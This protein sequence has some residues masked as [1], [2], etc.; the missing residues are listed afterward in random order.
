M[1]HPFL[2][3]E[4]AEDAQEACTRIDLWRLRK[5]EELARFDPS[6]PYALSRGVLF[7]RL[8]RFPAAVQS[9]RDYLVA[10]NGGRYALRARNYLAAANARAAEER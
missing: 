10:D 4:S 7:Y 2:E 5:V 9:F 8:G 3:A 6:Y 1:T